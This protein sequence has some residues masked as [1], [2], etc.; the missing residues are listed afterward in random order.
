[1]YQQV[2]VGGEQ[3]AVA[4]F[5]VSFELG[6]VRQE[7]IEASVQTLVVHI[8]EPHTEDVLERR[9]PAPVLGDMEF[10]RRLAE[11]RQHE[12]RR[13]L[14]PRHLLLA[15]RQGRLAELV[16]SQRLPQLVGEPNIA[17]NST[18]L[19]TH[20]VALDLQ[21]PDLAG[22]LE[23]LLLSRVRTEEV[24]R[25]CRRLGSALCIQ[26]AKL[27]DGHL[28]HLAADALGLHEPPVR[29]RLAVLL[30]LRVA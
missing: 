12:N 19:D 26:F 1:M 29:V 13:D 9:P 21:R 20:L 15:L 5:E 25:E 17:E 14:R 22:V 16:E 11:A 27:R 7:L 2:E 18:A 28:A 23:Q 24:L 4:L 30:D 8:L 3:R 6:F 10:A